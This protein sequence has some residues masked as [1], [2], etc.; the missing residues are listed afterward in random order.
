MA[1]DLSA[2]PDEVRA[3]IAMQAATIAHLQAQL[4][5][6]R[7][8]QFGRSSERLASS[9]AQFELALE[10]LEEQQALTELNDAAPV[11]PVIGDNGL[12]AIA[13]IAD[14]SIHA[15]TLRPSAG[16]CRP[17]ATAA[18]MGSTQMDTSPRRH[19]GPM[20]AATSTISMSSRS[21]RRWPARRWSVSPNSM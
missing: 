2:L 5:K 8:M 20:S 16:S 10:D 11:A 9:I 19:A 17:M 21:N 14:L 6:L 18:S 3:L 12:K 7:R 13:P 1:L 15:H 4:A